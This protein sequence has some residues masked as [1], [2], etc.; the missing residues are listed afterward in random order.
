MTIPFDATLS[1]R[2]D[3]PDLTVEGDGDGTFNLISGP[4]RGSDKDQWFH[5]DQRQIAS[6]LDFFD[7]PH[8]KRV[9]DL[10]RASV[11]PADTAADMHAADLWATLT[12][13]ERWTLVASVVDLEREHNP[14]SEI[15]RL[16]EQLQTAARYYEADARAAA[17]ADPT[18]TIADAWK[19]LPADVQARVG[20]AMVEQARQEIPNSE[21]ARLA[22]RPEIAALLDPAQR[23]DTKIKPFMDVATVIEHVQERRATKRG[24]ADALSAADKMMLACEVAGIDIPDDPRWRAGAFWRES[25]DELRQPIGWL[26]CLQALADRPDLCAAVVRRVAANLEKGLLTDEA[27]AWNEV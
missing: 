1:Q 9:A 19:A 22:Q 6:L 7:T 16:A 21:L 18:A 17:P 14:D 2:Y 4:I 10:A 3:F 20:A 11:T 27:F 25:I 5:L 26:L 8:G 12:R 24:V 13:D 23:G 15:V